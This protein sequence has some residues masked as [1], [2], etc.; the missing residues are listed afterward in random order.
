MTLFVLFWSRLI[1]AHRASKAPR[2]SGSAGGKAAHRIASPSVQCLKSTSRSRSSS[3]R[4]TMCGD[5]FPTTGDPSKDPSSGL[6]KRLTNHRRLI[7][8]PTDPGS[9]FRGHSRTLAQA[10]VCPGAVGMKGAHLELR[11]VAHPRVGHE[12]GDLLSKTAGGRNH[13]GPL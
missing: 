4:R 3:S 12:L 6:R 8:A 1:L 2:S 7:A 9:L 10:K 5:P 11:S 13:R